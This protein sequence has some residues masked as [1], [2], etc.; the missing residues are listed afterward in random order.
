MVKRR[1]VEGAAVGRPVPRLYLIPGSHACRAAMLMLEHKGLAWR[2]YEFIPGIQT[3][4]MRPLGFLGRTVPALKLDGVRV[5]GNRQ[6]ARFLDQIEPDPPLLPRHRLAAI[7]E[8]ERFA[9]EVLQTVARRLALAAGS[10][11]L[12]LLAD[13][14]D[15]GRLGPILA[16]RRGRRRRVM[17]MAARYF[18][19]SDRTEA[20]DLAALP[21]VLDQVDS[22]VDSGVLDGPEL[23]AADFQ[24]AP[25]LCLLAYRLDLRETVESR[26]AFHLAERLLPAAIGG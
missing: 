4:A 3:V 17:W 24:I 7:E 22:L 25:S 19:V 21:G 20:L 5:Q 9:D 10:R 13:H 15:A 16:R 11:D 18:G 2:P 6:I 14:G 23:N 12:S 26:P 1:P 8:A